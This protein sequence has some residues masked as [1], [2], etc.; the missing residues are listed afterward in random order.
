[1]FH[2]PGVYAWARSDEWHDATLDAMATTAELVAAFR[3]ARGDADD[4]DVAR[5][6][7]GLCEAAYAA[8]PQIAFDPVAFA[9]ALAERAGSDAAGYLGRCRAGE[10]H[11]A[12]ACAAGDRAAIGALERGYGA[13]IAS[14]IRRFTSADHGAED[15]RQI[16]LQRLL[17]AEPGKRPKIAEYAGQ[18]FLENWLRVTAVRTFLDL[19]KRK[20]RAREVP[21]GEDDILALP[22]PG[23]LAL[24]HLKAGYRGHVARALRDAALALDA[25]DRHLLRQHLVAGMTIDQLAAVLGVHRATA[26]RRIARAR[27]QLLDRTREVLGDR[28]GIG[29]DEVDSVMGLVASRLDVSVGR[30]LASREA[31]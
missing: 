25:G 28:L 22:E 4:G 24:D 27:E 6:L 13:V 1:M 8:H 11:L 20:D 17:V 30:L 19:R 2:T 3:A 23:D 16:L 5:A 15:L 9:R 31:S 18:G 21:A 29:A 10:L 26:A 14:V 7:A 12:L